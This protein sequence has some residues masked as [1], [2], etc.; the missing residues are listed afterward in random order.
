MA[1]TWGVIKLIKV[2]MA[3]LGVSALRSIK[4]NVQ[5][6]RGS[7]VKS[8]REAISKHD[9]FVTSWRNVDQHLKTVP[10][11]G[12]ISHIDTWFANVFIIRILGNK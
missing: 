4:P 8:R 6:L 10:G 2:G 3:C 5:Q 7:Y 1:N 12:C 11:E 9:D